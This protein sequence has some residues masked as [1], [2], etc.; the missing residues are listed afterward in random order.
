MTEWKWAMLALLPLLRG[1]EMQRTWAV[2]FV[3]SLA[4]FVIHGPVAY[5]AID[6]LA[7]ALI[8]VRPAGLA[9]RM[10]GALFV[11]MLMFD[12]GFYLSPGAD[13]NLFRSIL[14]GIG[15]VQWLILGVWTSHD[16]WRHH[17]GNADLVHRVSPA[18]QGRTR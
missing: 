2:M 17:R 18:R 9:Q 8:M 7:A 12:L 13:G 11:V 6:A 1:R 10:I 14:T 16:L 5:M 4:T 15:W 3:A